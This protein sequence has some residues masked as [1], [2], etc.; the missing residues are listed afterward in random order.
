MVPVTQYGGSRIEDKNL[1]KSDCE[2]IRTAVSVIHDLVTLHGG[3]RRQNI[4]ARQDGEDT[5]FSIIESG[6]SES[7]LDRKRLLD[8]N[9]ELEKLLAGLSHAEDGG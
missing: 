6:L 3:V 9:N 5:R 1:N 4:L 8:E 7:T 2:K